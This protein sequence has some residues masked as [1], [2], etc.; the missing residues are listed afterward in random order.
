VFFGYICAKRG[1]PLTAS[2]VNAIL[3]SVEFSS[4]PVESLVPLNARRSVDQFA[5]A[6]AKGHTGSRSGNAEFPFNFGTP[7]FEG[8]GDSDRSFND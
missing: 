7:Y 1:R 8:N 3:K 6:L 4:G 2:F 5:F